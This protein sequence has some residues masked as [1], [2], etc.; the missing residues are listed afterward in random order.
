MYYAV[1]VQNSLQYFTASDF[2]H[3][4]RNAVRNCQDYQGTSIAIELGHISGNVK[5]VKV[6]PLQL[7]WDTSEVSRLSGYV[8]SNRAGTHQ[9][10]CQDCQG[11]SFTIELG[12]V[13]FYFL[14]NVI[15]LNGKIW[16]RLKKKE[17]LC[18]DGKEFCLLKMA[19]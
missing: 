14:R 13:S 9:R 8:Y 10:K 7:N 4:F 19:K 2:Q 3:C 5:I 1:L 6:L 12:H 17:T 18:D 15:T 16:I 11:T